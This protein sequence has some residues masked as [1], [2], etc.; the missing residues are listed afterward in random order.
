MK[1]SNWY[2]EEIVIC[3]KQLL[4][5]NYDPTNTRNR[6]W[7]DR[8]EFCLDILAGFING[9]MMIATNPLPPLRKQFP[10]L[11]WKYANYEE[12]MSSKKELQMLA[13]VS[14]CDIFWFAIDGHGWE[15]VLATRKE[16][17]RNHSPKCLFGSVSQVQDVEIFGDSVIETRYRERYLETRKIRERNRP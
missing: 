11:D 2:H 13:D 16:F 10:F 5:D 7:L 9:S 15:L 3:L 1:I 12:G 8:S 14:S 4:N 17:P 6:G